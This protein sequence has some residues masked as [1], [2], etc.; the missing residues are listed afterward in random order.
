MTFFAAAV[1]A[2]ATWYPAPDWTDKP[3]PVASVHAKKG[4]RVRFYGAAAPKS[5]NAYVD[6]N[7]YTSMMFS[8]MYSPLIS[9]DTETMD[10]VPYLAEKWSVSDDGT[11]FVFVIDRRA[12]W[13]DGHPVSAHDVKWTFDAL[14]DPKSDTG[15]WK[16]ILGDFYS[17][18]ILDAGEARPLTVRFRKKGSSVR[19]WRDVMNCGTF[20]V[21]PSHAFRGRDFNKLDFLNAPSGGPY[22]VTRIE[23]QVETEYSRVT[24][25]WR[26]DFPSC[27]HLFNFDRIV[28]RYYVDNENGYAAL[29]KNSLDVYPVYSARLWAKAAKGKLF[30]RNWLV[31]RRVTNHEPVGYQGFAMNMRIA[32][33]D[34]VRVRK[35][36]AKLI[37]RVTMNRTMMYNEYFMQNSFFGDLYDDDNPCPNE[38][39]LFDPEG[40]RELLREAGYAMNPATGMIEKDGRPFEFNFLSRSPSDDK[41]LVPFYAA[42]KGVGIKMNVI[43]KDFANWMKDMD[44]FNFQM[45]WAAMGATVFRNPEILWLSSEADRKQSGNY[46]GFRSAEVDRLIAAEKSMMTLAERNDVYRRIDRLIAEQHPY[47]FLWNISAKRL[48]YWNKFGMPDTVLSRYSDEESVLSYWWYDPDKAE[49]LERAKSKGAFLPSVPVEVDY[50]KK[51]GKAQ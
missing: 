18:E 23:E 7:T 51:I 34:D 6:N 25:W 37:D 17:P 4:G 32:P 13:S 30:D 11:E 1:L 27:R 12:T 3:D 10:F 8:L 29:V 41:V 38:L 42:L 36:M 22:R 16:T 43:R 21:L 39:V 49:E 45:T 44:E 15:P 20:W 40:A 48:I 9:T 46:T 26:K 47:A 19:N 14:V 33:F 2:A 24:T 35:A 28:M 31:K 5:L 50:D